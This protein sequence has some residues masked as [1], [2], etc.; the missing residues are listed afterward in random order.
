M[1]VDHPFNIFTGWADI[2]NNFY[3]SDAGDVYEARGWEI[4]GGYRS[5]ISTGS[6]LGSG[7]YAYGGHVAIEMFGYHDISWPSEDSLHALR[8][9]CS[10]A[11]EQGLLTSAYTVLGHDED[12]DFH[13]YQCPGPAMLDMIHHWPDIYQL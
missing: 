2:S 8:N 10:C 11:V 13:N 5:E 12:Y 3:I 4:N 1:T 7:V 6:Y 9:F